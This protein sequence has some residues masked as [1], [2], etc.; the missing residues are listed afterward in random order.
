MNDAGRILVP[1]VHEVNH[2]LAAIMIS[3]EAAQ[4]WLSGDAPN[5]AEARNAIEII[6]GNS[7][8]AV[9]VLDGVRHLIDLAPAAPSCRDRDGQ[10][11]AA[12]REP[13]LV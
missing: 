13:V 5:L 4:R 3:A 7:R 1:A 2:P 11:P 8:R 9:D 12:T 10:T 6:I